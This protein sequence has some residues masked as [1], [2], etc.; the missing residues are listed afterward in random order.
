MNLKDLEFTLSRFADASIFGE[1]ERESLK[2]ARDIVAAF[3]QPT[4]FGRLQH[5]G[6]GFADLA[7][8]PAP[9]QPQAIVR[10]PSSDGSQVRPLRCCRPA[11]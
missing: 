11:T 10:L 6:S 8:V 4:T 2:C 9:E 1:G 3:V 7:Q 5:P